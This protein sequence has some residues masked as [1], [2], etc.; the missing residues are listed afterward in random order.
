[1]QK[2]AATDIAF[3]EGKFDF[4]E[5]GQNFKK[6]CHV[7]VALG[8]INNETIWQYVYTGPVYMLTDSFQGASTFASRTKVSLFKPLDLKSI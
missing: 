8:D 4:S 1:M 5:Q 3:W 2:C 7:L 6:S